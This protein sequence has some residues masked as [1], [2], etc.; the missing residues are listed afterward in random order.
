M[1]ADKSTDTRLSESFK[2]TRSSA[3]TFTSVS[4]VTANVVSK[5]GRSSTPPSS[6][7]VL[8]T[9]GGLGSPL[10]SNSNAPISME[11]AATR[12]KSTPRW[13]VSNGL[14]LSSTARAKLPAS[15]AGLLG[16]RAWVCVGPPLS[17]SGPSCGSSGLD[18]VPNRLPKLLVMGCVMLSATPIKLLLIVRL[19][20]KLAIKSV[21]G[22][23]GV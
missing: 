13:S 8:R 19:L 6:R 12:S 2:T 23:S 5:S 17:A 9:T 3:S 11:D 16:R 22:V 18:A 14:P 15:K 7:T 21:G 4:N 20:S 1:T 10:M